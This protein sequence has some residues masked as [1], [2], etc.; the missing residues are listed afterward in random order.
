MNALAENKA[1]LT[2]LQIELLKSLKYM[3]S[4]EQVAEVKSLLRYYFAQQLD[5]AIDKA[6]SEKNYTA[7]IYESWLKAKTD[8]GNS[9]TA[10]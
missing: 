1:P 3:A 2:S 7:A 5:T 4:E 9:F 10:A 8:S 6:E